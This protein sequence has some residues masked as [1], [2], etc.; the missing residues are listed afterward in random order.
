MLPFL[1][2]S[3]FYN[4]RNMVKQTPGSKRHALNK[5]KTRIPIRRTAI[6]RCMLAAGCINLPTATND[7][8]RKVAINK[9][10]DILRD[11]TLVADQEGG[12]T[13]SLHHLKTAMQFHKIT[14]LGEFVRPTRKAG[15]TAP[16]ASAPQDITV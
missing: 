12:S 7:Y 8:L 9:L 6:N 2:F 3:H 4:N 14:M 11:A 10:R 1:S 16:Q 13:L 5:K 15:S